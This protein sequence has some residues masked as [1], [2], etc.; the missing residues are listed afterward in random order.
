MI[1][2]YEQLLMTDQPNFAAAATVRSKRSEL[3]GKETFSCP[4]LTKLKVIENWGMDAAENIVII[5]VIIKTEGWT[6][7]KNIIGL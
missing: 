6:P 7:Q 4:A 3:R 1:G 5:I 2:R